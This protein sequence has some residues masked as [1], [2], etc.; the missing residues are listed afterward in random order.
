MK[1][2]YDTIGGGYEDAMKRIPSEE[3]LKKFVLKFP[4]DPSYDNLVKAK[5]DND[6]EAAFVAAHTLKGVAANLGFKTL[7]EAA[8]RLTEELRPKQNFPADDY[9]QAVD[10]AYNDV[11]AQIKKI[12]A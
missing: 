5:A 2:F 4:A 3:I 1:Q 10:A 6:V 8:S 7:T 9:F 12:E 11:M